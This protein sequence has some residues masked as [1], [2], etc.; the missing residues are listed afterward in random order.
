MIETDILDYRR[1]MIALGIIAC[2]LFA[3]V[4]I[5][6]RWLSIGEEKSGEISAD[7]AM[8]NALGMAQG[9]IQKDLSGH[10][11]YRDERG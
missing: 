8:L 2:I 5:T 10:R 7:Y 4:F 11:P 1:A 3:G 9:T 6:G